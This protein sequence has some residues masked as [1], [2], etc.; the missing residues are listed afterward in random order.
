MVKALN[1]AKKL[2]RFVVVIPDWDILKYADHNTYGIDKVLNRVLIWM[3]MNMSRAV[4]MR[5]DQLYR[6]KHGAVTAAEPKFIWVKMLQRMPSSDKVLMVRSKFNW[7]LE[8][9][10]V[11]RKHHYVIDIN[12]ILWDH[13]YFNNLNDLNNDGLILFW[14]EIDE[15]IHLFDKHK[16]S[17]R[18]RKTEKDEKNDSV[19]QIHFKMPPPPPH[20]VLCWSN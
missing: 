12:P 18:L 2:P 3:L 5:K 4:D 7:M 14:K 13:E 9:L 11:D 10:L 19:A 20:L 1:D 15:C 17:L 6:V 8:T 16:L